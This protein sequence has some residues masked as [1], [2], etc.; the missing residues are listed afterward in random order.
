MQLGGWVG[1]GCGWGEGS[2]CPTLSFTPLILAFEYSSI[3]DIHQTYI[4]ANSYQMSCINHNNKQD[5]D[6]IFQF[7]AKSLG[8]KGV[9]PIYRPHTFMMSHF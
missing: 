7:W 3:F 8:V 9:G 1:V 6:I 5:T 2:I 4:E